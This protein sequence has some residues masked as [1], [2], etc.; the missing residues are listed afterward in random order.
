MQGSVLKE[1]ER[2]TGNM[3]MTV[4]A[5]LLGRIHDRLQNEDDLTTA[6]AHVREA[7]SLVH[8]VAMSNVSDHEQ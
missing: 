7:L 4:V 6:A 3:S 2:A 8:E 5:A 1:F